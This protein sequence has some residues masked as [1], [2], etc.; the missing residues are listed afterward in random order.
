MSTFDFRILLETV[1]GQKTSY[2]SQS[3]VDTNTE[4][5]LNTSSVEVNM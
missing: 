3:F 5:V 2:I 1:E 4:L